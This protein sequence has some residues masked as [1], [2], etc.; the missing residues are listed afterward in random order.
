MWYA[1]CIAGKHEHWEDMIARMRGIGAELFNVRALI[2]AV[3]WALVEYRT[4]FGVYEVGGQ[5]IAGPA[6]C[7]VCVAD[8]WI[9][10]LPLS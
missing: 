5:H 10:L 9:A 4:K 8:S 6:C 2:D 7:G 1:R 3:A